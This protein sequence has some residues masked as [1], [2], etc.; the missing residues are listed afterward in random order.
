ME[1]F[2][3][4]NIVVYLLMINE[5]LSHNFHPYSILTGYVS[6]SQMANVLGV[7]PGQAFMHNSYFYTQQP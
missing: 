1:E 3:K 7:K 2:S 5:T 4:K 6:D